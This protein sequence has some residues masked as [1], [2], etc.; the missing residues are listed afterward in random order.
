MNR[1][2]AIN[3]NEDNIT[4]SK[5]ET[6]SSPF[7][8]RLI[9]SSGWP[10]SDP[11]KRRIT[12]GSVMAPRG[13]FSRRILRQAGERPA[14]GQPGR[15]SLVKRQ[16]FIPFPRTGKRSAGS[17]GEQNQIYV[18]ENEEG[19]NDYEDLEAM[20]DNYSNDEYSY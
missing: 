12:R 16:S 1:I 10:K 8:R 4:I 15:T 11:F 14:P 2:E 17:A 5:V 18:Y 6:R 9:R 19:N 7:S 20:N 3:N 13:V